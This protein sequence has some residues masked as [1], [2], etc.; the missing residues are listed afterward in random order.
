[1]WSMV[2]RI[3]MVL[4]PYN[5]RMGTAIGYQQVLIDK[6]VSKWE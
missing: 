2:V 5:K 1:M 6:R 4:C 3:D